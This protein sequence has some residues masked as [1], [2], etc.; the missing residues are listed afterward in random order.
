MSSYQIR[1]IATIIAIC[2]LDGFDV[3]AITFAAPSLLAEWGIGKA[4]L[5]IAISVG[6]IGMAAGSL[7]LAPL[8]D[9]FGRRK[10]ALSAL[11]IMIVGT[12]WTSTVNSIEMLVTS[13]LLTVL[14]FE[15]I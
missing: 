6:L 9:Q 12:A 10:M 4:Q 11:V 1:A 15:L 5:G 7:F 2:A 8:A 3:F 14:K 13:R